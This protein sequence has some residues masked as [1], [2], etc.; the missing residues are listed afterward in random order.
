MKLIVIV[1][2]ALYLY[3]LSFGIFM[4]E[5]FRLPAPLL[6]CF[7][8]LLLFKEKSNGFHY[9]KEL[10]AFIAALFCYYI[11][12]LSDIPSF[13]ANII[14]VVVCILYF[15]YFISSNTNRF[16]FSI[17]I[18]YLL[19]TFSSVVMVLN[20]F[21]P[22][23][24]NLRGFLMDEAVLQSPSG[25][26]ISQFTFGYQLA[27]LCP[28]I[29][30]YTFLFHKRLLVKVVIFL[31]CLVFIYLGMQRSVFITFASSIAIFSLLYFRLKSVFVIAAGV[32]AGLLFYNYVLENNVNGQDN[33]LTKQIDNKDPEFNR[34]LL[35]SENLNIYAN[36]PLGL[37]FYGKDWG[38]AIYRN[39]TFSSGVTSH[40]AYLMFLT[41]LG[42]FLGLGLLILIY[43]S[44]VRIAFNAL[45]EIRLKKNALLICLCFSF[46]AI[47]INAFS[48]NAWLISA[49]GPTLFLYFSI[50]HLNKLQTEESQLAQS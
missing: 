47:S 39:Q 26:A 13:A 34:I 22:Q 50:L 40:N 20:H 32:F 12:G 43:S 33:I 19:L 27:A 23:I 6:F 49:D 2:M 3:A 31:T 11:I 24:D 28:F 17:L 1:F 7:P 35:T 9:R 41:Y 42:P 36:Y 38:D 45:K 46:L 25:I 16:Y 4:T 18:F 29:L 44:I 48:H 21:S 37:V 8:L 30:L 14:S 15:N 5:T 10:W